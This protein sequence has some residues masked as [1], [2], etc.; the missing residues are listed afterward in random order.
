MPTYDY[1]CEN[2]ECKCTMTVEQ[3]IT[4]PKLVDCP[5][6]KQQTLKRLIGGTGAFTL[7]GTGWFKT[8]GY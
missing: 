3:K 2:P 7:S 8:G 6:C 5:E 1:L 4:D